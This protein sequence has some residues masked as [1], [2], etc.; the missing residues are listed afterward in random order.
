[1]KYLFPPI[2]LVGIGPQII[3]TNYSGL[4]IG[5]LRTGNGGEYIS[6]EFEKY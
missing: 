3:V 2:D 1:M 5:T 6:K 4:S